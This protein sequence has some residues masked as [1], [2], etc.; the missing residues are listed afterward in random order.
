VG[1][2]PMVLLATAAT[3]IASQAL[4]SGLYSL[5]MQAVQLDYSPRVRI[6]HTSSTAYGQ[7]FI[8]SVNWGLL[9][10]CVGLV[11]G[12]QSSAALAAAYGVAVTATMLITTALFVVVVRQCF[13]WSLPRVIAFTAGFGALEF[14]FFGANL[15]K[16]PDGGWFP[17]VVGAIVFTVLTTWHTGRQLVRKRIR[18]AE[19]S[20]H[21]FLH[22][23]F[24]QPDAPARVPRYRHLPL[25][26]SRSCPAGAHHEPSAPP[27]AP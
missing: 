2:I 21:Q 9:A 7:V 27:R 13:G 5:T 26:R 16:I 15:F 1:V 17:L 10:A 12:F 8:P 25:R 20:L 23:L 6:E 3:V 22:H 4:I 24:A 18:R 11:L 14:G 19:V